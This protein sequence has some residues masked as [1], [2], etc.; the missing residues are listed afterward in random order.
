R[1]QG[2]H[3]CPFCKEFVAIDAT[4]CKWCTADIEPGQVDDEDVVEITTQQRV[5]E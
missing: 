4:K 1:A 3:E 2:S 5:A